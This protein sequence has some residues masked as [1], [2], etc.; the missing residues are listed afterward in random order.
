M[1][2]E[3][4]KE[5]LKNVSIDDLI[6]YILERQNEGNYNRLEIEYSMNRI[7]VFRVEFF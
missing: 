5:T 3:I 1:L 4:E 6:T 7:K 2:N